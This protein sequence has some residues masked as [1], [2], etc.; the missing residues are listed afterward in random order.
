MK[1]IAWYK[2]LALA[3][4]RREYGC[5]LIEGRRAVEQVLTYHR[6]CVEELLCV[7][8]AASS[9]PTST[10]VPIRTISGPNMK[11]ICTSKTPQGIA[12]LVR[13]PADTYTSK[14][15]E[16]SKKSQRVLLLEHIQDP[17]NA[18]TL[19]RTAAAFG[20]DGVIMS[21]Q[22][23]DPFSP[24]VVQST[25]GSVLSLWIRKTDQYISM[26]DELKNQHKYKLIAADLNGSESHEFIK[27]VNQHILALGNEGSGL[28]GG[29]L[30]RCDYRIK[31]PIVESGAE[32]LNVA[33][34]GAI[35]MFMLSSRR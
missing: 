8:D 23:A 20:V 4:N 7:D 15:P 14:I 28:S 30:D 32:S 17:G 3:K 18:G 21:D 35:C 5:F 31:I 29:I 26:A 22:C 33:S 19:I 16:S 13:I 2:S 34:S 24:K 1:P 25:A 9:I 10:G 12:A 11:S 27:G 6:A